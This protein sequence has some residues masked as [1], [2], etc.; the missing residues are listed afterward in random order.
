M[1]VLVK[2]R[3]VELRRRGGSYKQ[4]SEATGVPESTVKSICRRTPTGGESG[5]SGECNQCQAVLVQSGTSRR[6]CSAKCR[7]AW[8]HEHPERLD[9]KALYTFV[10]AGCG[11][12]FTAY[13][14]RTRK[15]CTHACYV[16]T[17]FGTRGGKP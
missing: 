9:R 2:E 15:Y 1:D 5:A 14:N 3:V 7:L 13:G 16:K 10:C 17:R 11:A 8:W 4:I 12:Q 6:F